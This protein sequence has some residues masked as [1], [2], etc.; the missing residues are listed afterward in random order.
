MGLTASVLGWFGAAA[1]D[2]SA[3]AVAELAGVPVSAITLS[4]AAA[5]PDLDHAAY[6][7][8][9][10]FRCGLGDPYPALVH[11]VR[12]PVAGADRDP[13]VVVLP[14]AG[15]GCEAHQIWP[16]VAAAAGF[17]AICLGYPSAPVV[18]QICAG[19]D[20]PDCAER[21]RAELVFGD[22]RSP[23]IELSPANAVEG[24]LGA[25]LGTLA[26]LDRD[27]GW[28]R[29]LARDGRPRWE[30][31]FV[32]GF[33]QGAGHVGLLARD[34]AL[35]RAI[36]LSGG[37][38]PDPAEPGGLA[39]WCAADG[40]A[41]PP[42]STLLAWHREEIGASALDALAAA[43][44]VRAWI[45]ETPTAHPYGVVGWDPYVPVD[46]DGWPLAPVVD[47]ELRLLLAP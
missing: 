40:R 47:A 3:P 23:L 42:A 6:C 1:V 43:W 32:V 33:G 29:Y 20:A 35:G 19:D 34:R 46:A 13:L 8:G 30:R 26:G 2:A 25:L 39:G 7:V 5:D 9:E 21:V 36:L 44:Q 24:R 28:R 37:C 27:G 11:E 16:T 41:T 15:A 14:G 12:V 10:P 17:R 22:D 31:I 18:A 4:A 38:D 45:D